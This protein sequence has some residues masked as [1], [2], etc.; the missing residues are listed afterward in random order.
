MYLVAYGMQEVAGEM[1]RDRLVALSRAQGMNSPGPVAERGGGG[2]VGPGGA[3]PG[4]DGDAKAVDATA[5][6]AY[7]AAVALLETLSDLVA[8]SGPLLAASDGQVR[9]NPVVAQ[10]RDASA[11]V[12]M[13]AR[14]FGFT[15]AARQPLR[16]ETRTGCC[17]R[18][19]C[20][21]S[22]AADQL[23]RPRP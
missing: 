23:L 22:S 19:G 21:R 9:K 17:R 7:C 14:E 1:R 8:R 20:C 2:G 12:R 3:G 4:S 15:P 16:V 11:E 18:S 10:R 13:W 6:G 5:L